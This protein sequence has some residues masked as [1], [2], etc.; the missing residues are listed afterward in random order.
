MHNLNVGISCYHIS[1]GRIF[2]DFHSARVISRDDD[3][4]VI[5]ACYDRHGLS[6]ITGCPGTYR[7]TVKYRSVTV[8]WRGIYQRESVSLTERKILI[9]IPISGWPAQQLYVCQL[10]SR[11]VLASS[12]SMRCIFP[13]N[14]FKK[15]LCTTV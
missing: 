2:E 5:G 10:Q 14:D 8:Y 15:V 3:L 12:L 6:S 1:G 4:A 13:E 11:R 9:V 7:T